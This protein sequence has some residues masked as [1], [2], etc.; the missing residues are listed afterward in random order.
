MKY[1]FYN[2]Y[3]L[4]LFILFSFLLFYFGRIITG[5]FYN[6]YN[7][8]SGVG[9]Q[10]IGKFIAP[11]KFLGIYVLLLTSISFIGFYWS[12]KNNYLGVNRGFVYSIIF[13]LSLALIYTGL[14]LY[15]FI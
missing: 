2:Y 4:L 7:A 15:L 5:K 12:S 3:T 14:V 10:I 8:N 6:A 9:E 13:S 1:K 11:L